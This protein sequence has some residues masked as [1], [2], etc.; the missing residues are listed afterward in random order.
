MENI[1]LKPLK[2]ELQ[3]L[4]QYASL[5][6]RLL[7]NPIPI[8]EGF[9]QAFGK[10]GASVRDLRYE[11]ADLAEAN[12]T[13]NLLKFTGVV[14]VRLDRLEVT[15]FQSPDEKTAG[16]IVVDAWKIIKATNA[17]VE[18]AEHGVTV[19]LHAE[20]PAIVS[21]DAMLKRYVTI[22]S[23]LKSHTRSGV[24]FYVG[25]DQSR[26]EKGGSIVLEHSLLKP[27]SLSI[28]VAAVF[29]GT[30]VPIDALGPNMEAFFTRLLGSLGLAI[31]RSEQK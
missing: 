15:F 1:L 20:L 18:I 23:E 31:D 14:K 25:E 30:K 28:K 26:G 9:L 3:Y 12:I 4:G 13:C 5:A 7:A 27:G 19:S 11:T 29:D 17:S 24:A 16:E 6:L 8:Y 22:P 2:V 10:Y 21:C